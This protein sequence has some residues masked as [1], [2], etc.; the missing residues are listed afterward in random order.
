MAV[1]Q[2]TWHKNVCLLFEINVPS[3]TLPTIYVII[4]SFWKTWQL[5]V[6]SRFTIFKKN[7]L[8]LFFGR[9]G[10]N[11]FLQ[12]KNICVLIQMNLHANQ[13]FFL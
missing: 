7:A 13:K 9:S 4:F 12:H 8:I 2:V 11:N 10:T 6:L 3:D 5:A 1:E